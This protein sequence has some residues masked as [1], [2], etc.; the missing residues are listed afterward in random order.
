V[1]ETYNISLNL[2]RDE[3]LALLSY[4]AIGLHVLAIARGD[5]GSLSPDEFNSHLGYI[6]ADAAD[7]LTQKLTAAIRPSNLDEGS[8]PS[9]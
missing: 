2:D 7:R 8:N 6:N 3:V 5:G 9:S 4:I 1:P